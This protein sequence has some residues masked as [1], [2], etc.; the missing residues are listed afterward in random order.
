M[1]RSAGRDCCVRAQPE[2]ASR[3]LGAEYGD[4][5]RQPQLD[6]RTAGP[7]GRR[8]R[9]PGWRWGLGLGV[10]HGMAAIAALLADAGPVGAE[11][12]AAIDRAAVFLERSQSPDGTWANAWGHDLGET[13]LAG[14]ALVAAGRPLDSPAVVA[15]ANAVRRLA[16]SNTQT[17]DHALA[18]MFLDRMGRSADAL[19]LKQ[20]A[21][22]LM[23]GQCESGSWSYR[24]PLSPGS[25]AGGFFGLMGDNS[26]T[27]FA[28]I[29]AWIARR[30][31]IANDAALRRLDQHFRTTFNESEGGWGY[32]GSGLATP[33]MTCAGLVGLATQRG[34][35]QQ[36]SPESGPRGR[37][38]D[39][40]VAKRA[41]VALGQELRRAD[42]DNSQT[43]NQDLYFFWSLE[44]VGVIYDVRDIG[45]VDWYRWGSKRLLRGQSADGHWEGTGSKGMRF[46]GHVGTAFGILFLSRANAAA[47]LT[48]QVGSGG[49]AGAEAP[50]LGGG[51][52]LIQ[53]RSAGD[54]PPPVSAVPAGRPSSPVR[55]PESKGKPATAGPGVLDPFQK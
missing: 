41:L 5:E 3:P 6:I 40:P 21:L 7:M 53:R 8:S 24:L 50:G 42:Q 33:T 28:A 29:A 45:G 1:Q 30:H 15:A 35:L 2:R 26:N 14:M 46:S 39:D 19:I 38:A 11:V 22:R 43:I 37:A 47:D 49:G 12:A 54:A 25:S 13:A 44:R 17:Y 32:V 27:Q 31:G 23:A 10:I 55:R 4:H 9:S 52:Q 51:S 18:I 48:A 16:E 20:L 34:A 36:R